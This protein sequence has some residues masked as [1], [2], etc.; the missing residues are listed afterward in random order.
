[1]SYWLVKNV[2]TPEVV[3]VALRST[4]R[5]IVAAL[6]EA[7]VSGAPSWARPSRSSRRS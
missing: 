1:M 3:T 5:E 4:H 6:L 2:M 7:K